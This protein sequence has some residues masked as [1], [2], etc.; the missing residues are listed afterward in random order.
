MIHSSSLGI[1]PCTLIHASLCC[2]I[3]LMML[4][5]FP[6][7]PSAFMSWHRIRND[8]VTVS[9]GSGWSFEARL[10]P[11]RLCGSGEAG[12][13]ELELLRSGGCTGFFAL[14]CPFVLYLFLGKMGFFSNLETL[15]NGRREEM[16]KE[17]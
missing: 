11:T 8:V 7:T 13:A 12:L 10:D 6:I 9:Y 14:L 3:D 4:S 5:D 16:L 2:R 1:N 15:E 17:G